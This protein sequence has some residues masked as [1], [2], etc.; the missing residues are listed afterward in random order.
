MEFFVVIC[1]IFVK[2]FSKTLFLEQNKSFGNKKITKL[3]NDVATGGI[4]EGGVVLGEPVVDAREPDVDQIKV[5]Q[6]REHRLV[7]ALAEGK[8]QRQDPVGGPV[9]GLKTLIFLNFLK[10]LRKTIIFDFSIIDLIFFIIE[11]YYRFFDFFKIIKKVT[12]RFFLIF[13]FF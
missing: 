3:R 13:S 6:V 2:Y 5:L 8:R 7:E 10:S 4:E 11:N 1:I 9:D 12:F